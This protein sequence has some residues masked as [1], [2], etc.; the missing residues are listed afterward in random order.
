MAN[1]E[2]RTTKDGKTRY[3]VLVR[4][5][6]QPATSATFKRVTD[7]KK[8]AADTESAIREG[9]YF[10]TSEARKKTLGDLI[11]RYKVDVMPRKSEAL[12][13]QQTAQLEWWRKKIGAHVLADVT[14]ALIAETRDDFARSPVGKKERSAGSVN[15]YLAALSHAFTV[16]VREW[17]WLDRNPV[18]SVSRLKEPRGRVRFLSDD[19]RDRLL[20]ACKESAH[21]VLYP[22]VI[23][24]LSTGCREGELL[25]LRWP[26]VDLD[27]GVILLL[28]TKNDERRAVPLMGLARDV[29][30]E[31]A[32]VRRIDDDQVFQITVSRLRSPWAKAL[33]AAKIDDFRFHDLRHS[34]A[35]YLAMNGASL[36]EI[37]HVLGHKTLVM[38]KRYSHLS[39]QHTSSIVE[40]MNKK[41]FGE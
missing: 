33:K 26:Q 6:G 1:I 2:K 40:K 4:L 21:P 28:N 32:K 38:V 29:L 9:R 15:R 8:W 36:V 37:A 22:L 27:R 3:R 39:E 18:K 14:P 10:K 20:K 11:D 30:K 25:S 17:G 12:R 24:A 34:A 5:K 35:S 13:K 7:A 16:S 19:E 31:L 41:I 23:T